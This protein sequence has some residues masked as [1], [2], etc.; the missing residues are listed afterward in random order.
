MSEVKGGR[1]KNQTVIAGQVV[2]DL[3]VSFIY[4]VPDFYSHPLSGA[5]HASPPLFVGL[6]GNPAG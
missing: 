3:L 4:Q 2:C 5:P 6:F 1:Q